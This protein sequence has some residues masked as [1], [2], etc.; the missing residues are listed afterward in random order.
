M[1]D[2]SDLERKLAAVLYADVAGYSRL[3][4]AD[5]EGTHRALRASLDVIAG[6]VVSHRGRVIHYAGDAVLAEFA[7]VLDALKCAI[8]VQ[9]EFGARNAPLPEDQRLQFRIGI[10]LGDV[11]VDRDEL[12]GDGVNVAARLE[13]LADPGGI[14]VSRPVYD[15]VHNKSDADFEFMGEQ[16]VK[17]IAEPVHA[18]RVN[19][20]QV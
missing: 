8:A 20:G 13:T 4:G 7:S 9:T 10:N 5:E 6:E 18:Y 19:F 1:A 16:M 2:S 3:T 15:Q 12:Y 11:I 17:N 14:C